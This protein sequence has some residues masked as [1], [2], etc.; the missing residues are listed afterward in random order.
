MSQCPKCRRR[1]RAEAENCLCGWSAIAERV[2]RH[3]NCAYAPACT[4][5]AV[6]VRQTPHGT[7]YLCAFHD[8]EEHTIRAQAWCEDRGMDTTEKKIDY[9]REMMKQLGQKKNPKAWMHNPK[10]DLARKFR[11]ELLAERRLP[12]REPGEDDEERIAA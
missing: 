6:Y 2:E 11:D 4:Q 9:C 3:L 12:V 5:S 10:S 1:L 7:R 8:L